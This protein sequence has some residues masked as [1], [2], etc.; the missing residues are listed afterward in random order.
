MRFRE[1]A[2]LVS[3]P[4]EVVL[5]RMRVIATALEAR[6]QGEEGEFYDEPPKRRGGFRRR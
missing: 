1:D 6:V 3:N 2:V 5:E 4:D